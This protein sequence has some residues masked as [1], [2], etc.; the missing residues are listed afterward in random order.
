MAILDKVFTPEK[1]SEINAALAAAE[2]AQIAIDQAKRAGF[3][4]ASHQAQLTKAVDQ[5][6]QI[7]SVFY[8]NQ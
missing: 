8:P 4:T 2:D 3:D 1:L 6:R 7:K 5:L